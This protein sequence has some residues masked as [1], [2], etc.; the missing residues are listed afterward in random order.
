MRLDPQAIPIQTI[1]L[2][3]AELSELQS[4][5]ENEVQPEFE[6]ASGVASAN[7][8][9]GLK[10]EIQVNLNQDLLR[11]FGLT[12]SQIVQT[13][14]AENSSMSAGTVERGGDDVQIRI[15]GE[16]TSVDDIRNTQIAL[17]SGETI[18]VRDVAEVLD[19]YEEQTTI[20]RVNGEDTLTF[21]IMKQSDGNTISVAKEVN[22]VIA[23]L[24][25]GV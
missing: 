12:G 8:T 3:G 5:A 7:I 21:S 25:T 1:S 20:S 19:T 9:G 6:R 10:R 22:K 16:Y 13:L 11:N 4:I 18:K 24:N 23:K 14:G 2:T 15:D 17:P